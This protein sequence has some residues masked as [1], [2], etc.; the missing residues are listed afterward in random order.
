M[1][2]SNGKRAS[3]DSHARRFTDCFIGTLHASALMIMT[4]FG[5]NSLIRRSPGQGSRHILRN[6]LDCPQ[7]PADV[8]RRAVA[9]RK[10]R[11]AVQR[12]P[13][14]DRSAAGGF[15]RRTLR[16]ADCSSRSG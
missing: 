8:E 11:D 13:G 1:D 9:T 10:P 4:N 3:S 16:L 14:G 6:G 12:V 15:W 7:K 5:T 2:F